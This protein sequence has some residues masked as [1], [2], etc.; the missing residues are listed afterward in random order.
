MMTV[1]SVV[2]ETPYNFKEKFRKEVTASQYILVL[3]R[4]N[5]HF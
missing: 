3:P 4:E 5:T 1:F 2:K